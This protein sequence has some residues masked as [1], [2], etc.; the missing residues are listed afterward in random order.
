V[1]TEWRKIHLKSGT[2]GVLTLTK[3]SKGKDEIEIRGSE[4][5]KRDRGDNEEMQGTR[6]NGVF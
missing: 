4:L 1:K 6:D 2:E 3:W 5:T